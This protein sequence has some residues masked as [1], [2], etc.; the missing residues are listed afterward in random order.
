VVLGRTVEPIAAIPAQ[1]SVLF[2][3]I[4]IVLTAVDDTLGG[5]IL[6]HPLHMDASSE[7]WVCHSSSSR[8]NPRTSSDNP[9]GDC[10]G[11][12][13]TCSAA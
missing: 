3:V 2:V 6:E 13:R 10:A 11:V 7:G 1:G 5:E 4:Q 8:A 12:S 9:S